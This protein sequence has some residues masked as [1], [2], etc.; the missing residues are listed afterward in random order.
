[1]SWSK[2][3]AL[4]T[5]LHDVLTLRLR[6]ERLR[7]TAELKNASSHLQAMGIPADVIE[8]AFKR[9]TPTP[10][11]YELPPIRHLNVTSTGD[12]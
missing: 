11:T 10:V 3:P 5:L 12:F 4:P 6:V 7:I 8:T 9:V 1:M 2:D